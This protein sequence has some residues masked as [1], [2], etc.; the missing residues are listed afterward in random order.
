M[1]RCDISQIIICLTVVQPIC[2][3]EPGQDYDN[4]TALVTGWGRLES[5]GS[6]PDILQEVEVETMT[7]RACARSHG[8]H[9][10]TNNMICA[11]SQ[12]R[13]ACWGDSGGPL[14]V[15]GQDGSFRQIGVVSWGNG[16]G[17]PGYPGVY[18]R[19][20]SLLAWIQ[21]RIKLPSQGT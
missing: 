21:D 15:M 18:T 8:D 17:T 20:S 3:P 5:R 10:I 1:M 16:C 2:L 9:K 13:D 14:A 7:N 12:G 11:G 6:Q 19:V 4:V